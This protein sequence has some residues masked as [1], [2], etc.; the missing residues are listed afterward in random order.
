MYVK[1]ET[2]TLHNKTYAQLE[3]A[4]NKRIKFYVKQGFKEFQMKVSTLHRQD[5][6]EVTIYAE[7]S[8]TSRIT[9]K[10]VL[11]ALNRNLDKYSRKI[12]VYRL[13]SSLLSASEKEKKIWKKSLK[14]MA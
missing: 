8:L 2:F 1:K 10:L 6:S 9:P 3:K 14:D 4:I 13:I 7:D 11:K 12:L 5:L